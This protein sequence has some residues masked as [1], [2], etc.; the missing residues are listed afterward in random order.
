MT[1][2]ETRSQ[3]LK[4]LGKMFRADTTENLIAFRDFLYFYFLN[5]WGPMEAGD[6]ATRLGQEQ[7]TVTEGL[8]RGIE[9][10]RVDA[11]RGRA[12]GFRVTYHAIKRP[13]AVVREY[14]PASVGG[15]RDPG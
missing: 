3:A 6:L 11:V 5:E 7:A 14:Y 12:P 13:P 15:G 1:D 10:G 9:L 4:D 2:D 8:E